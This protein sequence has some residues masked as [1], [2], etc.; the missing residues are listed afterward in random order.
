MMEI[1]KK[2]YRVV[3]HIPPL[4]SSHKLLFNHKKDIFI[5]KYKI[6]IIILKLWKI[7]YN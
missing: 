3:Q 7:F 6:F 5:F 2:N 4:L 1:M